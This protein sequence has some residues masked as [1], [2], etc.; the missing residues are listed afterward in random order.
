MPVA[1]FLA[2]VGAAG[3][4]DDALLQERLFRAARWGEAC[5][6]SSAH[7]RGLT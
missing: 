6:L 7:W 1:R 4:A 3:E 2:A 5:C